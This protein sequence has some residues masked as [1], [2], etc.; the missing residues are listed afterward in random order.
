M[1]VQI[2][3]RRT[4][5]MAVQISRRRT[6]VTDVPISRR[7]NGRVSSRRTIEHSYRDPAML[8]CRSLRNFHT[9]RCQAE[10][11]LDLEWPCDFSAS[12]CEQA[13]RNNPIAT[14]DC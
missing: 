7:R 10:F 6:L 5:V 1:G 13:K 2:S 14:E 9:H 11:V 8:H 3:K 4:S 12:C